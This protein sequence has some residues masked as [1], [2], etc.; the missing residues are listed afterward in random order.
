MAAWPDGVI[1]TELQTARDAI[2]SVIDILFTLPG[3]RSSVRRRKKASHAGQAK[4]RT[5]KTQSRQ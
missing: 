4:R 2:Q 3:R 1:L 5:G